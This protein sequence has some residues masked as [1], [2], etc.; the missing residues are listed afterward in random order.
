MMPLPQDLHGWQATVRNMIARA[1]PDGVTPAVVNRIRILSTEARTYSG[2]IQTV[3]I[4]EIDPP[5]SNGD[6]VSATE[7]LFNLH[8]AWSAGREDFTSPPASLIYSIEQLDK[9]NTV[10]S[11]TNAAQSNTN[12]FVVSAVVAITSSILLLPYI[13]GVVI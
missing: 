6:R 11:M 3:V 12:I 5:R 13:D 1:N 8:L 10:I 7:L 2:Q 9:D 4:F